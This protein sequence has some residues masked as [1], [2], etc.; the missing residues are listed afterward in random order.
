MGRRRN[1]RSEK[2]AGIDIQ[3][4]SL[5]VTHTFTGWHSNGLA[6]TRIDLYKGAIFDGCDR[7]AR[8]ATHHLTRP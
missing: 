3:R 5:A 7:K 1:K 2:T 6:A 4:H 8:Q